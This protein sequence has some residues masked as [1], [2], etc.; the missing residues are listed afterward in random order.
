MSFCRLSKWGDGPDLWGPPTAPR[1]LKLNSGVFE[2]TEFPA[3][4]FRFFFDRSDL[5]ITLRQG[6]RLE[7]EWKMSIDKIDAGLWLPIFVDGIR[8]KKEPYLFTAIHGAHSL[9]ADGNKAQILSCIPQVVYLLKAALDTHDFATIMTTLK[10]IQ[11]LACCSRETGVKL[12]EFFPQLLPVLNRFK[13]HK[14]NVGDQMDFGQHSMDGRLVG[15]TIEETLSVL[16]ANGGRKAFA[17]IKS[18]VPTFE[19]V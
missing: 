14:R 12:V 1:N 11:A 15:E 10:V 6:V 9:I 5:P 3:T 4:Q 18:F 7:F 13:S 2:A 19:V 8:E 16:H 17:A